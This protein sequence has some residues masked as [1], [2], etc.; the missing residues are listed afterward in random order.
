MFGSI[1]KSKGHLRSTALEPKAHRCG[2]FPR[3]GPGG[4]GRQLSEGRLIIRASDN[5]G[6]RA[7][8]HSPTAP[9]AC[10]QGTNSL[11]HH[12]RAHAAGGF[13]A[14]HGSQEEPPCR[15]CTLTICRSQ[16]KSELFACEPSL[17]RAPAFGLKV[18]FFR[19]R[20][21]SSMPGTST[22][23]GRL[24]SRSKRSSKPPMRWP[25]SPPTVSVCPPRLEPR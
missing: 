11:G 2:G 22:E 20:S 10:R 19:W 17:R 9:V 16:S 13:P 18:L 8:W 5:S 4:P 24:R 21:K 1:D 12:D 23:S 25:T 7:C 3:G 15:L 14:Y 6:N